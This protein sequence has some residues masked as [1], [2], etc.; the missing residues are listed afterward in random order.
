MQNLSSGKSFKSNSIY[1]ESS[2]SLFSGLAP[3]LR[4]LRGANSNF[5]GDGSLDSFKN[6]AN[7]FAPEKC[8]PEQMSFMNV[9]LH[10]STNFL[11]KK[12]SF[13]DFF[14]DWNSTVIGTPSPE[15]RGISPELPSTPVANAKAQT[16]KKARR[17]KK[18]KKT[19]KKKSVETLKREFLDQQ[20]AVLDKYASKTLEKRKFGDLL[21]K[22]LPK[23]YLEGAPQCEF[24]LDKESA[25]YVRAILA[26]VVTGFLGEKNMRNLLLLKIEQGS[27]LLDKEQILQKPDQMRKRFFRKFFDF[28]VREADFKAR[29]AE[30]VASKR[31]SEPLFFE[32]CF[33]KEKMNYIALF[34]LLFAEKDDV[35]FKA[36]VLFKYFKETNYKKFIRSPKKQKKPGNLI[37]EV[38]KKVLSDAFLK[39]K[40]LQFL[41]RPEHFA[42]RSIA[43]IK[44]KVLSFLL[45]EE[46]FSFGKMAFALQKQF[47]KIKRCKEIPRFCL[48]K[49]AR[50]FRFDLQSD[51]PH[52]KISPAKQ[53]PLA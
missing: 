50:Q 47:T 32:G 24:G 44:A 29:I 30:F 27:V 16:K 38:Y 18:A 46:K 3:P 1:S 34:R 7:N 26:I 4:N 9:P 49:S 53:R 21:D 43:K 36:H 5:E 52:F 14:E 41:G 15:K 25:P 11:C 20:I 23:I 45:R 33:G 39:G 51:C 48:Q 8:S 6:F 10:S 31:E 13:G 28:L 19:N 40:Y 17:L 2:G 37:S 42:L 35:D 22:M 12:R